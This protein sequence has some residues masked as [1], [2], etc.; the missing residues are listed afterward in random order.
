MQS[1]LGSIK[2]AFQPESIRFLLCDPLTPSFAPTSTM[3]KSKGISKESSCC[4][5]LDTMINSPS[6][7]KSR[8][9]S[10]MLRRFKK[11]KDDLNKINK[12]A[13]DI[14]Y[15]DAKRERK[16]E[17]I[18]LINRFK[19][20]GVTE[21]MISERQRF[22]EKG[23]RCYIIIWGNRKGFSKLLSSLRQVDVIISHDLKSDLAVIGISLLC[24]EI[25]LF[26]FSHS[27]YTKDYLNRKGLI[28][29][30]IL[31]VIQTLCYKASKA[32]ILVPSTTHQDWLHKLLKRYK[33]KK[34]IY[35]LPHTISHNISGQCNK[36]SNTYGKER[37]IKIIVSDSFDENK[38]VDL[39]LKI[40]EKLRDEIKLEVQYLG[41]LPKGKHKWVKSQYINNA[42]GIIEEYSKHDLLYNAVVQRVIPLFVILCINKRQ[43]MHCL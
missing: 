19:R 43:Q 25:K 14:K 10:L 23:I 13:A 4:K 6:S 26:N 1:G 39:L 3:I 2:I 30:S 33:I 35:E 40:L 16:P 31:V 22:A 15:F 18:L 27:E 34:K 7:L 12:G 37:V 20:C 11:R 9:T 28:K 8:A 38:K 24:K 32:K 21:S 29:G 36:R 17:V 42:K 41:S 5:I